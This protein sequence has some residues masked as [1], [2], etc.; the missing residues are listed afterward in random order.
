MVILDMFMCIDYVLILI[1]GLKRNY[2]CL[3]VCVIEQFN[4]IFVK[5]S[6]DVVLGLLYCIIIFF[7]YY[8]VVYD[9]LELYM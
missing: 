9:G 6:L 4:I 1:L 5:F 8:N 7:Y 2:L 3:F